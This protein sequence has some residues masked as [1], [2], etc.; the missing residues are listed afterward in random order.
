MFMVYPG[1][2][3]EEGTSL[4]DFEQLQ[5]ALL[6]MSIKEGREAVEELISASFFDAATVEDIYR[7]GRIAGRYIRMD[8]RTALEVLAAIGW[9][10]E[11]SGNGK[12][13]G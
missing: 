13:E 6:A 5:F 8:Q 12:E 7:A 2:M 1:T 10:C 4:S 11:E 3:T 9:L